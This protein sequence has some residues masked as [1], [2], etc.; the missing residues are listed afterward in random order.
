MTRAII[1][2]LLL[3]IPL[4]VCVTL[5]CF[6]LVSLLPGDAART[7][8]GI[9]AQPQAVARLQAQL[10]L[11]LPIY[12]QYWNWVTH[13]LA[14]NLGQ[15]I[16]SGEAVATELNQRLPVTGALILGAVLVSLIVGVGLGVLSAVRG[17]VTGRLVDSVS[18]LGFAVPAYW[19]GAELII[20][21]AVDH[22]WFPAGGYVS[23]GTSLGDW[24]HSLALPVVALAVA[25]I[26]GIAR[27][28][29]V[30]MLEILNSE[31][32]R[33]AQ[34]NGISHRSILFRHA[35]RNAGVPIAT[36]AG[37]QAISLLG[38]TVLVESVFALPGLGGLAV[39]AT[40]QHDLPVIEGIVLYFTIMV[41]LINLAVDI[42]CTWLNPRLRQA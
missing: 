10:G 7:I 9:Q 35:L 27:Q 14:G 22:R 21:F 32:V 17:G 6:V 28:T 38:G 42:V 8:L 20:F 11:N 23:P 4:L 19:L 16:Y 26:A 5:L 25:G 40:E 13:A 29:R 33:M 37:L 24:L 3:A 30:A 36:L 18:L 39:S 12:Q 1:H 34:A 31:Y 2:R 41:V 15:S